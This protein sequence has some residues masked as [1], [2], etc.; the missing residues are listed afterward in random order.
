MSSSTSNN[1]ICFERVNIKKKHLLTYSFREG[2]D[3]VFKS[4]LN[5][6]LLTKAG[7]QSNL[8]QFV[9][10]DNEEKNYLFESFY[11]P[12]IKI[13]S[14]YGRIKENSFEKSVT[15]LLKK[16]NGT[17]IAHYFGLKIN[18]FWDSCEN[19]TLARSVLKYDE[20]EEKHISWFQNLYFHKE[21]YIFFKSMEKVIQHSIKLTIQFESTLIHRPFS[22]ICRFVSNLNNFSQYDLDF[23]K[24][25]CIEYKILEKIEKSEKF[26][27]KFAKYLN[28]TQEIKRISIFVIKLSPIS[29]YVSIE[30]EFNSSIDSKLLSQISAHQKNLLHFLK[31]NI[32]KMTF[33]S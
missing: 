9:E 17:L 3:Q 13:V 10:I 27:L 14:Q 8:F 26:L 4:Y 22:Q 11:T 32:E 33:G 20:R 6:K 12:M 31:D 15:F 30:N 25:Y 2:I 21:K 5:P 19:V 29:C 1:S 16:F 24:L 28:G 18:F 23:F 7:K